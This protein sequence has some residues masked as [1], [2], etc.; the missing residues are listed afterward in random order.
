[1]PFHPT[2]ESVVSTLVHPL[3][4]APVV[5]LGMTRSGRII[6]PVMGG[7][8]PAGEPPSPGQQPAPPAGPSAPPGPSPQPSPGQQPPPPMFPPSPATGA[9]NENGYP[10]HT[11]VQ[12]MSAEQQTAYWRAYARRNEDRI[13]AM[14]D[15]ADLKLQAEAYRKHL[16]ETATE[17]QKAVTA[18]EARGRQTALAEAGSQM[19][20][21]YVRAAASGRM[22]EEQ[23]SALLQGLDR[24]RFVNPGTGQVDAQM[25]SG[26]I[27]MLAPQQPPGVVPAPAYAPPMPAQNG[28]VPPV[29]QWPGQPHVPF[30]QVGQ[31]PQLY[32]PQQGQQ[33]WPT[34]PPQSAQQ[35]SPPDMG[36]ERQVPRYGQAQFPAAPVSGLEAGKAFAR[37]RFGVKPAQQ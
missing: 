18:A 27:A 17:H 8:Q 1:M 7:S 16:D 35:P 2:W 37:S 11:P 21:A 24:T 32:P 22:H 5:P 28:Q 10:D 15:Y 26:Y 31:P 36:G 23:V 12:H 33:P 3:T 14:G 13:K 6:W 29:A 20:E 9:V 19:V 4:G 34:Y 25:I 30:S